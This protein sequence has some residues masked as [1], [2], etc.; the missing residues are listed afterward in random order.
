LPPHSRT[1]VQVDEEPGLESTDVSAS[2]SATAPIHVERAMYF[3]KPG[4]P[5]TA[6]HESAGVPAPGLEWFLAEGSTGPFFDT[7]VLI[8]NPNP[9]AAS[10]AVEY[11]L[12]GGGVLT[13]QYTVA[14]SSRFT[15]WVDDEE[16]TAGSGQK[17]L[18]NVA[19]STTVRSTNN[20]PIVVERTMWWPGP[21]SSANYWYEAHNSAGA[22]ATASRWVV[23]D[24]E[25]GGTPS[26]ETYVLI[27]NPAATA[28]VARVSLLFDDGR[29]QTLGNLLGSYALPPKSRTNIPIGGTFPAVA[30]RPFGVV[31]ESVGSMAPLVVERA[32]YASPGGV[33]WSSGTGALATPLP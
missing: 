14:P 18:L 6:G 4:Q 3:S 33:T 7:F 13:K 29:G 28:A 5:F 24:G 12:I 17:P 15:I 23:A 26:A 22:T 1:T 30:G 2:I 9:N 25:V 16:L 27:A 31:V 8:A 20:V 21:E 11:L 19:F 32:T 10:V